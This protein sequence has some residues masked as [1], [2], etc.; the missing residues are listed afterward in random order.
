[1]S[2][3]TRLFGKK[4]T[5][6]AP[7]PS[8]APLPKTATPAPAARHREIASCNAVPD[9]LYAMASSSG[10]TRQAAIERAVMLRYAVFLPALAA[11]LNDWVLPVRDAARTALIALLPV[12]PPQSMLAI[13][14]ALAQLRSAGRYVHAEWLAAFEAALLAQLTP[15]LLL[16]G[17]CGTDAKVARACFQLL[18][19][20]AAID[21]AKLITAALASR[22]DIVIARHAA[23][24][25]RL[26]PPAAQ[27][28]LYQAAQ[29]SPFWA[30]RAIGLRGLLGGPASD[31]KHATAMRHLFDCQ[32]AQR[33]AA[34]A[35]FAAHQLDARGAYLQALAAGTN[36]APVLQACLMALGG[37]RQREDA[38]SVRAFAAYPS[39]KVRSAA[40]AAWLK[41]DNASK[42]EIAAMA[43]GDSAPS[44]K[45]LAMQMV[46]RHGAFIPFA[47]ACVHLSQ[48]QDWPALM[49]LGAN[50]TWDV[51]E[52]VAR[53]APTSDI[54]SRMDLRSK[55]EAWL[56]TDASDYRPTASQAAFLRS[57][58][59]NTALSALA[60]RDVHDVIERELARALGKRR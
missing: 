16:E 1:M 60:G 8:P 7:M 11:R 21:T 35:Y 31:D 22:R 46:S 39:A 36:S 54:R 27:Q 25:I 42:D 58:A 41:L 10:Y 26:V 56:V 53:I 48:P 32:C 2:L 20:H 15:A 51:I 55:L 6:D 50:G 47:V 24:M 12:M 30:V 33:D 29:A 18:Q 34:L 13:L 14:P 37:L 4:T 45:K 19:R 43:L 57:D 52:A 3:F 40:Y 23:A 5:G 28:A 44:V 49:R 17:V 9:L 38:S 59:A